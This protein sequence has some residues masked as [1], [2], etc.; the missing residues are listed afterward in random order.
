M[1]KNRGYVYPRA[2]SSVL[3]IA[4]YDASGKRRCKS[5]HTSDAKVAEKMLAAIQRKVR[6]QQEAGLSDL[7]PEMT[8]EQFCA[9]KFF[10]DRRET[11]EDWS[12]DEGRMRL[13]A[14]PSLGKLPLREVRAYHLITLFANLRKAEHLAPKSIYNVYGVLKALFREAI[15]LD[16]LEASPCVLDARHLGP[17][18]DKDPEW[19]DTAYFLRRELEQLI[20]DAR[21]PP[22]RQLLYAIKGIAACRNGE[23]CALRFRHWE[24]EAADPTTGALGRLTI[25]RS[26]RKTHSKTKRGRSM[27]VHPTLAAMLAEWRLSGWEKLMGRPPTPDDLI[28]PVGPQVEPAAL[29]AGPA[30]TADAPRVSV[31]EAALLAGRTERSVC[32]W[33][34]DGKLPAEKGAAGFTIQRDVLEHFLTVAVARNWGKGKRLQP[35]EMR[36]NST[37]QKRFLKDLALLGLR[38]RRGHDLRSTFI[39]LAQ[40]DGGLQ[41]ILEKCTH[42]PGNAKA[43]KGYT[44]YT[45]PVRSAEVAKFRITRAKRG[46]VVALS[47]VS[48]GYPSTPEASATVL[49]HPTSTGLK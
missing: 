40:E 45:W 2:D 17:N 39:T 19:R 5:S 7:G 28:V 27:P 49:L 38:E 43:I 24:P 20:S 37:V 6:A 11:I 8:V 46:G 26:H 16:L 31:K 21:I 23:V 41:N 33:I 34:A 18:E 29:P 1:S 15:L 30:L 3:G 25:A 44:I 9:R 13:H 48:G 12:S 35:G 22:D 14:F 42:T 32:M 10:P 47:G 4:F 36:T